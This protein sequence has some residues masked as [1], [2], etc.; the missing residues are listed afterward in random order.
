MFLSP[1]KKAGGGVSLEI[2][3]SEGGTIDVDGTQITFGAIDV[4]GTGITVGASQNIENNS[5]VEHTAERND[6]FAVFAYCDSSNI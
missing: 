1:R 5:I 4:G 3:A 6:G 2:E